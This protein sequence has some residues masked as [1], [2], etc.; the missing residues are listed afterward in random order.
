MAFQEKLTTHIECESCPI[1]HRAVCAK[2]DVDELELLADMKYYRTY[3]AGQTVIWSGDTMDFVASVVEG[4][5]TLSQ[6]ME[7]GRTQMVGLLLPSDFV[8]RP[9]R[10]EAAYDVVA[11]T[12]LTMCCFRRKPFEELMENT[13]H[14]GQ[15]LLQ[16]TLDELDAAREWMLLLGRKTARE[17]IASLLAIIARRDA[18]LNLISPKGKVVFDL[19]LTREAMADYLGLTLET[20]SRQISA[21]RRDGVIELEGKRHVTVPQ[22]SRLL[23]ET[24]DDTDG[25]VFA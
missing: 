13:P 23:D 24:G 21:L 25:G 10:D 18:T 4:I 14:I 2:C 5:A 12:R 17:K 20:V 7:D 1:R 11:T 15:R 3:D 19:P 8:G 6:T 22:M 16:M 9:G